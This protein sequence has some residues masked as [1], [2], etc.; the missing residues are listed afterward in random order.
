MSLI[1]ST[2][3]SSMTAFEEIYNFYSLFFGCT[4][5]TSANN[6]I[7]PA[8]T[9]TSGCYSS[10]FR[11]CT[12]LTTAPELPATTLAS[13]C[14]SRM[15]SRTNLTTA[16]EL[17][18]TTLA[19]NCYNAM[20]EYCVNLNYIKCLATDISA[21]RATSIWVNGVSSTGTFVK[22]PDMSSWGTGADGI[23]TGWTIQDA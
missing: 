9:L 20:F 7:L 12:N 8:T 21:R 11:G 2:G 5:L 10:M 1:N 23:P 14:Y 17:P 13:S 18:A 15:F 6:L 4:G 22:N 19:Q 3:F 16:P